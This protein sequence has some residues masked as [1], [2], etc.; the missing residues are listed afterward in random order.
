MDGILGCYLDVDGRLVDRHLNRQVISPDLDAYCSI[1]SRIIAS[2][3]PHK[4]AIML[5]VLR[6]ELASAIVTDADTD[7]ALLK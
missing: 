4:R 1:P 3:A 2:G 6:A 5:A 7:R